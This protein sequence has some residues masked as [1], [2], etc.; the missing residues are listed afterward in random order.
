MLAKIRNI[1]QVEVVLQSMGKDEYM[2]GFFFWLD[3]I[4]TASLVLDVTWV[5]PSGFCQLHTGCLRERVAFGT[6]SSAE[7]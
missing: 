4:A 7:L 1:K 2:W 3:I 5:S 6:R